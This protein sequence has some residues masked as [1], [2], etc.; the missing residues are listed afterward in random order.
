M[1]RIRT[2]LGLYRLDGHTAVP[3]D[4]LFE[5]AR[6]HHLADRQVALTEV[7]PGITVSTVF[8]GLDHGLMGPPQLFETMVFSDYGGGDM[9]RYATWDEA[10]AGHD[11]MVAKL[12]AKA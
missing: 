12:T 2:S 9:D 6:W 8:L 5:W 1:S 10:V 3:V 7:S 11:A 4:D